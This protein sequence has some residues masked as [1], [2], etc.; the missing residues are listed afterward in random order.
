MFK[1]PGAYSPSEVYG[2][3]INVTSFSRSVR[4]TNGRISVVCNFPLAGK[5]QNGGNVRIYGVRRRRRVV[6]HPQLGHAVLPLAAV[7]QRAAL[8]PGRVF[9]VDRYNRG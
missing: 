2:P 6:R 9:Q 4:A 5:K 1:S 3:Q 8:R 7:Y